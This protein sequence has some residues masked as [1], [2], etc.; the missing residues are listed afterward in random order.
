MERRLEVFLPDVPS[1][2]VHSAL[3]NPTPMTITITAGSQRVMWRTT[4]HEIRTEQTLWRRMHLAD[5][6]T[7]PEG[8]RKEALDN[9]LAR[10]RRILMNPSAWDTMRATDWDLVPQPIRTVAYRQ[11]VAYW[12]GF[13]HVGAKYELAPRRV[14]DTLAAIVMSESWFNHRGVFVN[15]DGTRD[16]GLAGASDFAR[17][18]LRELYHLGAV[19]VELDDNAYYNPWMAT[20]FVA[21]WMSLMLD[22]AGGDLEVAVRA[23]HRGILEAHDGLGTTYVET[24]RRRLTVFIRNQKAPPAWDYIW[25]RAR[26]IERQEWPWMQRRSRSKG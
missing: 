18:R 6:N 1:I 7:V 22:E 26:D 11:M 2:D 15:H 9:M 5:W 25:R 12:T 21:I 4:V 3:F 16:I 17:T 20:R 19:D 24:V 8:L 10:Y 23:Y 14:A 13:Y